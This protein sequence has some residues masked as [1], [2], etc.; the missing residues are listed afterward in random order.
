MPWFA[1][2]ERVAFDTA[3]DEAEG[4]PLQ[5]VGSMPMVAGPASVARRSGPEAV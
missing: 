5:P 1:P 4:V 2:C 3:A